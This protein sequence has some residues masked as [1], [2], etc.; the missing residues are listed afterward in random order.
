MWTGGA[1]EFQ[2]DE[3]A[4]LTADFWGRG[5]VPSKPLGWLEHPTCRRFINRRATGDEN[6][7]IIEYFRQRHFPT[8]P[9]LALSLGCGF[10]DFDR[11]VIKCNLARNVHACD[12]SSAAIAQA[13]NTAEAEGLGDRIEYSVADLNSIQLPLHKYDAV[14]AISSVHHVFQ[15]ET[16]FE[17]VRNTLKPGAPFFL[18]EFIGPSRFQSSPF[19]T[20]VINR[21]L[22]ALP[23]KYRLNLFSNDG[24]FVNGYAAPPIKW[25]EE[26]DPSEAVRSGEIMRTLKMYFDVIEYKAYGGGILHMLLSG[27]AGNFDPQDENDVCILTILN[28]LDEFLEKAEAIESDM[29]AI[30]CRAK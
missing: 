22:A 3:K 25:F 17:Q 9:D 5:K 15:L 18:D 11:M 23:Q 4:K 29:A 19:V 28:V 16:L 8:I 2:M 10:G 26:H 27:I 13:K 20:E 30:L 1:R 6:M 14:F 21:I 12:I 7:G 24:S